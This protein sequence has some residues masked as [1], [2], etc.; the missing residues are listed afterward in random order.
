MKNK[1]V[2]VRCTAGVFF[3][4]LKARRGAEI[5]LVKGRHIW[6]WTSNGLA[7]KALCVDDL[8]VLG[9]GTGTRISGPVDQ[10]LLGVSQIIPCS[11]AAAKTIEAL[12]CQ[13]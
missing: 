1:K 6:S 5:D 9:A 13:A 11:A 4:V 10:T 8:A 7:R 3:G 2:M 12:P